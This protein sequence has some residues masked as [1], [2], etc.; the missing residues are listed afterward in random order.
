L[1]NIHL[2]DLKEDRKVLRKYVLR[3]GDGWSWLRIVYNGGL[4]IAVL[5]IRV[6]LPEN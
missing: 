2:E 1:E 3:I 5:T 6:L 4:C